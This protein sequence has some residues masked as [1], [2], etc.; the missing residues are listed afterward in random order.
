VKFE[1]KRLF[2]IDEKMKPEIQKIII[3]KS[4]LFLSEMHMIVCISHQT[5]FISCRFFVNKANHL[6]DELVHPAIVI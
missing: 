1:I 6:D 4:I 2:I 3:K 5:S